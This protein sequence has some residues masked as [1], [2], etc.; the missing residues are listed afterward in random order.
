M[1]PGTRTGKIQY[2]FPTAPALM[3]KP[4]CL[5]FLS[6]SH[7]LHVSTSNPRLKFCQ[8]SPIEHP[9]CRNLLRLNPRRELPADGREQPPRQSSVFPGRL[10]L[11]KL[12]GL[13]QTEKNKS[14]YLSS[15]VQHF[16]HL[17]SLMS[18][19]AIFICWFVVL[20]SFYRHYLHAR[21]IRTLPG[22]LQTPFI[23]AFPWT[24]WHCL[25]ELEPKLL[26]K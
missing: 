26:S 6:V 21:A 1:T 8:M 3:S 20:F 18:K 16:T 13:P 22:P 24:G 4:H 19:L 2:E 7:Y 17:S 23:F 14:N 11:P 12:L 25:P 10:D 5:V 9:S 15:L